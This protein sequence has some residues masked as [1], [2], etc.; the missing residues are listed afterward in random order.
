MSQ[1][2]DVRLRGVA[3]D[4]F[5]RSEKT[6][7]DRWRKK[8]RSIK[9]G[10]NDA[11]MFVSGTGNQIVF[12]F[13]PVTIDNSEHKGSDEYEVTPS[14]RLRLDGGTWHPWMIQKYAEQLG[15]HADG[16]KPFEAH[17]NEWQERKRRRRRRRR[18]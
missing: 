6:M 7:F 11:V 17:F 9:F 10:P 16:I 15:L 2:Q 13:R 1:L 4:D 3:T 5:R 14:R 18:G 12:V 8:N